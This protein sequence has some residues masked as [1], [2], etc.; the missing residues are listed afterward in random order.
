MN[1]FD[2]L[3]AAFADQFGGLPPIKK[4][5]TPGTVS[6]VCTGLLL[7]NADIEINNREAINGVCVEDDECAS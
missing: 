7:G 5:V 6:A 2:R 3:D 4:P 1:Q